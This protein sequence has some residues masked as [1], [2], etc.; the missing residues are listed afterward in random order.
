MQNG[1]RK[2]AA[3]FLLLCFLKIDMKKAIILALCLHMGLY[4]GFNIRNN[5]VSSYN[6]KQ[7]GGLIYAEAEILYTSGRNDRNR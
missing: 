6:R 4:N 1:S 3:V 7:N 5:Y 2:M